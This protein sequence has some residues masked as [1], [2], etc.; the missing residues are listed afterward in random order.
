MSLLGYLLNGKF[1]PYIFAVYV[2]DSKWD[3]TLYTY[4]VLNLCDTE[5]CPRQY[6][7]VHYE[8]CTSTVI[9]M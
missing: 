8:C 9:S 1:V 4:N 6:C 5:I 7:H 2:C 3:S